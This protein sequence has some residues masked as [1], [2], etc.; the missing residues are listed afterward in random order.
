MEWDLYVYLGGLFREMSS[1]GLSRWRFAQIL[2]IMYI[3]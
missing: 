1:K 2:S 3:K